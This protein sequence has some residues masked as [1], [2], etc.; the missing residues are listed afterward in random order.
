MWHSQTQIT[1]IL[2]RAQPGGTDRAGG[3]SRTGRHYRTAGAVLAVGVRGS[4]RVLGTGR[5]W[6]K[7]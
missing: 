7:C 5:S 3:T 4:H 1:E 6:R 2:A